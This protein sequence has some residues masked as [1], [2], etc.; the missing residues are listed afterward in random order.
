MSLKKRILLELLITPATVVPVLF[1]GSLLLL[2]EILGGY[3]AFLGMAGLLV[4]FGA[5]LSNMLFNLEKITQRV[6]KQE[7]EQDIKKREKELDALDRRLSKTE[8]S[9]DENALRNLR[10]LYKSFCTDVAGRKLSEHVPSEM[11]QLIDDIFSSCVSKLERSYEIYK[12]SETMTGKLK[13]DLQLHRSTLITDVESSVLEL[14]GVINE[15][16]VL[17]FKT[18]STELRQLQRK[19]S[20]QL[21][22]AKAT[23]EGMA[24]IMN[25]EDYSVEQR[26]K[27]IE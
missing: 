4:G 6:L 13:R 1:G 22:I 20:S 25:G 17:K 23:E 10:N 26:L 24:E 9:S 27:D 5:F 12:T 8:G 21:E 15:V 19:L 2:C 18:E 7:R 16:R 11:L 3:A 14:A